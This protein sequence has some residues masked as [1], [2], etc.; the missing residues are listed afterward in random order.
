LLIVAAKFSKVGPEW[1]AYEVSR[2]VNDPKKDSLACISE[3]R[4]K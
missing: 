3:T 2:L 4:C 1:E